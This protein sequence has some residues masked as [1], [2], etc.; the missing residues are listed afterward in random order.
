MTAR[1]ASGPTGGPRPHLRVVDG[2]GGPDDAEVARRLQAQDPSAPALLMDRFG[3]LVDRVLRRILGDSPDHDDRVQETFLEVLRTVRALRDPSAFKAWVTTIAV[4]VARAELRR[5]RVRRLFTLWSPVE[6]PEVAH[7]DDHPGREELRAVFRILDELPTEDRIAFAL[8]VL[9]G[10]ELTEVAR[11][12]GC[13]LATAKRR[14]ARAEATFRAR[15]ADIPALA[16]RLRV[17]DE[18]AP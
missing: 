18:E 12:A 1:R 14:I 16:A 2:G 8:R 13:S 5:R 11:L 10:E 6:L 4:R 15:A 17:R 7:D 3:A 9:H